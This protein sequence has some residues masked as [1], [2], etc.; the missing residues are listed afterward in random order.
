MRR[1]DAD[2]L[3]CQSKPNSMLH[4]FKKGR[5]SLLHHLPG[6]PKSFREALQV[7]YNRSCD[8]EK[9]LTFEV[10]KLFDPD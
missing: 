6:R 2:P 7:V 9:C 3:Y 5:N 1:E 4:R 8:Y 10:R